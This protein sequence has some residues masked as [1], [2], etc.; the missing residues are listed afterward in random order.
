MSRQPPNVSVRGTI[1]HRLLVNALVDPGEAAR[2]LPPGVRPHRTDGGTVVGICLLDIAA[3]R[4]APLP[5]ALGV[6]L[7]AAA[8]RISAEWEDASGATTVGVY[9]PAR[10]T[11]SRTA[12]MVGGR[13]FPGVHEPAV[14]DVRASEREL[15]WSVQPLPKRREFTAAVRVTIAQT[16]PA[17]VDAP[18]AGTCIGATVGLSP[19]HRDSLEAVRMASAHRRARPVTVEDLESAFL[20]R[21]ASA[22][23]APSYLLEDVPVIWSREAAPPTLEAVA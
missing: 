23:P 3:I 16:A 1:R 2:H 15:A 21:F 11:S 8:H 18:V 12:V 10:L 20:A 7:R 19:D 13:A 6:H 22:E 4:P 9:V 14:I 5:A 17:P